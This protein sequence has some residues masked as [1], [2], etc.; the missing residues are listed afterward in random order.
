MPDRPI[1][2]YV[3][4]AM[5][6]PDPLA[7]LR[8]LQCGIRVSA[9]LL[10]EGFAVF[11]PFLDYQY[12]LTYGSAGPSVEAVQESSMAW[13]EVSDAVVVVAETDHENSVGTRAEISR[14]VALGIPVLYSGWPAIEFEALRRSIH[15]AE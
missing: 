10:R 1:R 14:A 3:A 9:W 6:D 12:W 15:G 5:R 13:L 11:S 2:I 7:F 8:N 4:G